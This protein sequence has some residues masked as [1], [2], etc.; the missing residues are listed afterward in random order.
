VVWGN[1]IYLL[2]AEPESATRY[3]LCF[4]TEDGAPRW[5]HEFPSEPHHRHVRNSFASTTPAVDQDYV[6]AAWS[7]PAKTTLMAFKHD[8]QTVWERDL[9]PFHSQHGFGTSPIVYKDLVFLCVQQQK[10]ERDGPQTETS[11][12]V[13]LDRTTG[14]PRWQTPRLSEV[15]SYSTPCIFQ[16]AGQPDQLIGCSTAHGIY[17]L[18]P[19]TGQPNWQLEVFD[20]RT[21]SSP[22]VA[23]GLIVGTTGSGGGGNYVVA[24]RPGPR[25]ET[26]Y[27]ITRQAPYVPSPVSTDGLLF[28]WSDRGIVT[29]VRVADGQQVWQQRIGGSFSG[30]PVIAGEHMYCIRDDGVVVVLAASGE[31]RL[32]AENPLGEPSRA[33]PAIS[34]G[35]MFLRTE[36]QL[37]AV[38]AAQ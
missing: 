19:G 38:G 4:S 11:K 25:P 34:E 22:L 32:L 15:V 1:Q 31:F 5:R 37:C 29:C 8:G 9:G 16:S 17:S 27:R 6:Y 14:E 23:G 24:L 28:L 7:T 30:S 21:V 33:T 26:A 13:A 2:S 36:S 18:D 35:R 20:K 10:P 3:V 12:I